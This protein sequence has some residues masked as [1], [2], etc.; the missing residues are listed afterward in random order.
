[1]SMSDFCF[2]EQRGAPTSTRTVTL[3]PDT[4]RRESSL[5]RAETAAP[6]DLAQR[7]ARLFHCRARRFEAD[8]GD[9]LRRRGAEAFGEMAGKAARTDRKSKRLHS[10]H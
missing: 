2:F 4:T 10:S 6:G 7:L 8:A 1:M 5:G 9:I 3:L